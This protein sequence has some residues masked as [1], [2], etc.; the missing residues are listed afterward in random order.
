MHACSLVRRLAFKKDTIPVPVQLRAPTSGA[1][2]NS[3]ALIVMYARRGKKKKNSPTDSGAVSWLPRRFV[4]F[5]RALTLAGVATL[6]RNGT[7][8]RQVEQKADIGR[9]YVNE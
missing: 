8:A 2:A 6:L 9:V 4:Y 1:L 7:V 5:L 3:A